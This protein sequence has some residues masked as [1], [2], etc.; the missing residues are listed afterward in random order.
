ML[1]TLLSLAAPLAH[2][3]TLSWDEAVS[4]AARQ[5]PDLLAAR[6]GVASGEASVGGARSGFLPQLS[7]NLGYNYGNSST[8][9]FSSN[10]LTNTASLSGDSRDAHGSYTANASLTQNLFAGFQDRAK[11]A[12][13]RANAEAARASLDGTRAQVSHDL[14]SAFVALEYAKDYV[15]L[16][17]DILKR[18]TANLKLVQLRFESGRENK[19]SVLLSRAYEDQARYD[20]LVA[21]NAREVA[22][23]DLARVLGRPEGEDL[24]GLDIRGT[25]PVDA[26]PA[27][28]P[29]F[30]SLAL[31]TPAYHEALAREDAADRAITAA[32]ANFYPSLNATGTVSRQGTPTS[33]QTDRWSVGLGLSFPFF[34]GGKDWYASEAAAQDWRA[35]LY[36]REAAGREARRDLTDAFTGYVAAVQRLKMDE[37]FRSAAKVRAEIARGKYENGLLSFEDWD[38]I[39]SDLI[40]REK[41]YLTSRRDRVVAEAAWEQAQGKGALR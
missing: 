17:E 30:A 4:Q 7:A 9:V 34:S 25:V 6:A 14:K 11:L 8:T 26:P 37:S 19:G 29:D 3:D 27:A 1:F 33:N 36:K 23:A 22:R 2:A 16:S 15:V 18:R 40:A 20:A 41:T 21:R 10:P 5:N 13:A 31:A 39:E 28:A 35:A 24:S 12:Q 38:Q 32:H